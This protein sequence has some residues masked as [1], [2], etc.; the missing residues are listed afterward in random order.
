MK[1]SIPEKRNL[2]TKEKNL[3]TFLISTEKPDWTDLIKN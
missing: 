3:L 1:Y 2:T